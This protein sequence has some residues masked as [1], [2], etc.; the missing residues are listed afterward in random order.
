VESAI[1]DESASS[2]GSTRFD[3]LNAPS[4]LHPGRSTNCRQMHFAPKY[5]LRVAAVCRKQAAAQ[6]GQGQQR[7]AA[8]RLLL[9]RYDRVER[10]IERREQRIRRMGGV[11][12][13]IIGERGQQR[14]DLVRRRPREA[15][16]DTTQRDEIDPDPDLG[17]QLACPLR[18]VGRQRRDAGRDQADAGRASG[19]RARA[20]PGRRARARCRRGCD[21]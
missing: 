10:R 19:S 9:V 11:G 7:L 17:E 13:E 21:G 3:R 14:I 8:L 5:L 15:A 1:H 2:Y 16:T 12:A 20:R 4:W 18:V 6:V